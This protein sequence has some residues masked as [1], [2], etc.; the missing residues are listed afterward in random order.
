MESNYQKYI[1]NHTDDKIKNK[2]NNIRILLSRL[3][4]IISKDD[5]DKVR[6]SLYEIEKKK[7]TY[8]NTK[9][10]DS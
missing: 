7:K 5:R 10:K 1:T 4:D 9:R 2:I 8:K 3:G 6:K